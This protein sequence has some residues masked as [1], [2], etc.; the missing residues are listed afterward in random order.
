MPLDRQ[1]PLGMTS[2]TKGMMKSATSAETILA[3]AAPIT[4]PTA[5][6]MT[7]PLNANF[8]KSAKK[9]MGGPQGFS[10]A[11][12]GIG[13]GASGMDGGDA[14]GGASSGQGQVGGL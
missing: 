12:G 13:G 14:V 4:T 3:K 1:S 5:R 2:A 9:D 11:A 10:V 8:L 6:S 7:F